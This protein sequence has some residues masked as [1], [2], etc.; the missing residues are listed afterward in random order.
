[1]SWAPQTNNRTDA[2]EVYR[3]QQPRTDAETQ[4]MSACAASGHTQAGRVPAEDKA[5]C[6]TMQPNT[7]LQIRKL[8]PNSPTGS[9]DHVCHKCLAVLAQACHAAAATRACWPL[10]G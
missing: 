5:A 8:T 6:S 9:I 4:Q 3:L 10:V 7:A 2:V 1:M